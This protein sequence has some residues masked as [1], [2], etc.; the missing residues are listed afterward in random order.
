M[1][2]IDANNLLSQL[3][4]L[5]EEINN[6]Y[7]SIRNNNENNYEL[8]QVSASLADSATKERDTRALIKAMSELNL[9]QG[10]ILTLNE[11]DQIKWEDKTIVVKPVYKWLLGL[12]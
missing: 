1:P 10:L 8:I 5:G 7:N 4:T 2:E 12:P 9:N 6:S 3:G 11:D